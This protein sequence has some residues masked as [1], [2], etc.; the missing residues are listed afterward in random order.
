MERKPIQIEESLHYRIKTQALKEKLTLG[1]FIMK[2]FLKYMSTLCILLIVSSCASTYTKVDPVNYDRYKHDQKIEKGMSMEDV[3]KK[4]GS[5]ADVKKT[6]YDAEYVTT[7]VYYR[8]IHC[9]AV[10]CFVSFDDDKEVINFDEFRQEYI[11]FL[12]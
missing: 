2:I 9:K 1:E 3:M 10:Y 5:P 12:K 4:F 11:N 8:A 6:V 7:F